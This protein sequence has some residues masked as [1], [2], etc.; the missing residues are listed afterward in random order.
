MAEKPDFLRRT[1][2]L[3]SLPSSEYRLGLVTW[4]SGTRPPWTFST[5][6]GSML[7][8]LTEERRAGLARRESVPALRRGG[9]AALGGR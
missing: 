6:E 3:A 7:L 9:G 4:E 8:K 2:G 5:M 1:P